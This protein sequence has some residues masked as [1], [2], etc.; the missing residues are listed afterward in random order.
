MASSKKQVLVLTFWI[1][2]QNV[3]KRIE[4]G[5]LADDCQNVNNPYIISQEYP[6]FFFT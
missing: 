3:E 4:K 2:S 1:G 6:F 5:I